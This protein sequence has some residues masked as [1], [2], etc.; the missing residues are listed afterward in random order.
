[1]RFNAVET[2]WRLGLRQSV[3]VHKNYI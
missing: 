3:A 2:D 1:M